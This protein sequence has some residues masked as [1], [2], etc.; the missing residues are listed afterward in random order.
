MRHGVTIATAPRQATRPPLSYVKL[1]PMLFHM[2]VLPNLMPHPTPSPPR[3]PHL[4]APLHTSVF[5]GMGHSLSH[6][7]SLS[8]SLSHLASLPCSIF[9]HSNNSNL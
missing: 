5:G 7:N 4:L 1:S 6:L 8:L 3:P 2:E 9:P